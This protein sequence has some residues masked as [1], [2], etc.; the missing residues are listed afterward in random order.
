MIRF[1]YPYIVV[2]FVMTPYI[3]VDVDHI[4]TDI[5]SGKRVYAFLGYETE[6][7]SEPNLSTHEF[8]NV[9]T[10]QRYVITSIEIGECP[11]ELPIPVDAR[12][13]A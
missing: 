3:L 7:F 13:K 8:T 5:I 4:L 11:S 6:Y 2:F 10:S 9:S 1:V 12:S